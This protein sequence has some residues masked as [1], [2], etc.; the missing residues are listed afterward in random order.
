LLPFPTSS[1]ISSI[2]PYNSST[3]SSSC[4]DIG[5]YTC[6]IKIFISAACSLI[7]MIQ[8]LQTIFITTLL[9]T[10]LCTTIV[11]TF[12]AVHP[13]NNTLYNRHFWFHLVLSIALYWHLECVTFITHN[14]RLRRSIRTASFH[15]LT[16]VSLQPM[17]KVLHNIFSIYPCLHVFYETPT[18]HPRTQNAIGIL[19]PTCSSSAKV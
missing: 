15:S 8:S 18:M 12:S 5:M 11:T 2:M 10:L 19:W 7:T 1:R 13:Q 4:S 9:T 17:H 16:R 14:F 6:I 3:L